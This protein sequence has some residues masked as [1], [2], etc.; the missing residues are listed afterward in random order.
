[1]AAIPSLARALDITA[2]AEGVGHP[3]QVRALAAL[4][5]E[6]ARG[7][8]FFRPQPPEALGALGAHL[9]AG[10]A[11]NWSSGPTR[12]WQDSNLRP[13]APEASALSTE[14]QAHADAA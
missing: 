13:L 9:F 1:M 5:C 10:Y 11:R 2:I 4:G 6:L 3:D 8:H 7:Y 14:L 12:A